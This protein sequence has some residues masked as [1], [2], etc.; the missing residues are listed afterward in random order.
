MRPPP[1]E[2]G[3]IIITLRASCGAVNC[4]RSYLFV[5]VCV[6]A[7]AY[8]GFHKGAS[9]PPLLPFLRNIGSAFYSQRAVFAFPLSANHFRLADT[10]RLLT[11]IMDYEISENVKR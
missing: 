11:I 2:E 8:L 10:C 6:C 5:G 3:R 9:N 7:V 4:N 1:R